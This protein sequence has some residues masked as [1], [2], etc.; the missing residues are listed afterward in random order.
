MSVEITRLMVEVAVGQGLKNL[1]RQFNRRVLRNAVEHGGR[2]SHGR[3]QQLLFQTL[4]EMLRSEDHPYYTLCSRLAN[5]VDERYLLGYGVNL[6][7]ESW[8]RGAKTIRRLESEEQCNIPWCLTIAT[9]GDG[10]QMDADTLCALIEQGMKVGVMTYLL[11]EQA[12]RAALLTQVCD[13]F[14]ACAITVLLP[15]EAITPHWLEEV[16]GIDN[17]APVAVRK[18]GAFLSTEALKASRRLFALC[19]EYDALTADRLMKTGDLRLAEEGS[20]QVVF[21]RPTADCPEDVRE[22]LNAYLLEKKLRPVHPVF[23]IDLS[24]DLSRVD[25]IISTDDC[26]LSIAV[27]GQYLLGEAMQPT[28]LYFPALPLYEAMHQL[29]KKT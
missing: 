28:W 3:F 5:E 17:L 24:Y 4:Q 21:F 1:R 23:P 18:S 10:K 22:R 12:A 7:F 6:G 13:R 26:R 15:D 2:F 16:R 8:T 11:E 27:D 29:L 14:P 25:R 9:A 20:G 19:R